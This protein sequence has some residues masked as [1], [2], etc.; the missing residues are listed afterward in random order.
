M[1]SKGKSVTYFLGYNTPHGFVSRFSELTGPGEGWRCLV[2]K[3]GPGSGKSTLLGR[4]ADHWRGQG[5]DVEIIR[6][7]SDTDSLDGVICPSLKICAADGT[8]PHSIELKYPGAVESII[9]LTSCWDTDAL[10]KDRAGIIALSKLCGRCHE[11]C[12]RYLGAAAAIRGD[13]RRIAAECLNERKLAGYCARLALREPGH[14]GENG[15]E[16]VRIL[17]AVTG[18]GVTAFVESAK[19]TCKRLY[20]INDEYGAVSG[21]LLDYMRTHALA[22]GCNVISCYCPLG[23]YD[24]LEHLFLPQTGTGFLTSN[25]FHDFSLD[26]DP[27]RIIN[28]RRFMD[29]DKLKEHRKRLSH[30][31]KAAAQ[32]V[33][34]AS[35]LL[36]EAKEAHKKLEGFYIQA[37]D[38]SKVDALTEKILAE[39]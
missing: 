29:E 10:F 18:E 4:L 7:S 22:A 27:Y 15:K 8:L 13:S 38:F 36:G 20:L 19:A 17:S 16:Q 6:C 3:G 24:K 9:D 1:I 35:V 5:R 12:C 31:K 14:K 30:N 37:T 39:F 32:M 21:A 28:S 33:A 11:H 34:G 26:I 23:P 25:S 2:I